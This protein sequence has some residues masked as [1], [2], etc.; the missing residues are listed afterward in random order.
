MSPLYIILIIVVLV[1]IWGIGQYNNLVR[2]REMVQNARGQIAAQMESRW[3]AVRTL[4]DGAKDYG[5][6]EAETL[7]NVIAQRTG[8]TDN[9]DVADLEDDANK[10][11]GL[12]NRL[13]GIVESY[14][15]LKASGLYE[16][17]MNA[18]QKYE[19]NV[20]HARMIYND[21]VT[22]INRMVQ[23]FPT[24]IVASL[25]GFEKEEYFQA[26]EEKTQA[27]TWN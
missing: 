22:K 10:F 19:E 17:A 21:T 6:Y 20:R 9:P 12:F 25:F 18:V 2:A 23:V 14:P 27:P 16:N 26:T 1:V 24:N 15:D 4:I 3:D 7:S 8:L 5:A 11:Q 13:L